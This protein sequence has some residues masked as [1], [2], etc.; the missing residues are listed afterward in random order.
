MQKFVLVALLAVIGA[1][2]DSNTPQK[3][4]V[5][6]GEPK[7]PGKEF[8][9]NWWRNFLIA[10]GLAEEEEP[11][12]VVPVEPE[13][14]EPEEPEIIRATEP[15]GDNCCIIYEGYHYEGNSFEQC[16]N[17]TG[18]LYSFVLEGQW[19]DMMSSWWCGKDAH[20]L[21]C[22]GVTED[23]L[24]CDT[25]QPFEGGKGIQ[26][27]PQVGFEIDDLTKVIVIGNVNASQSI[28]ITL[29][30]ERDC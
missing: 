10:I 9:G 30:S 14:V 2:Q 18:D 25:S 15:P 26:A 5:Y 6:A 20:Y 12:P 7:A 27:N 13:P 3:D 4:F 22:S 1:T 24:S 29:F 8:F 19:S 23:G 21:F 28:N 11:E 16:S 17:D